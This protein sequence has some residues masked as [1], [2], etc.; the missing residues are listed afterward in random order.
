MAVDL[1]I[2]QQ[3]NWGKTNASVITLAEKTVHTQEKYI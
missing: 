2:I 1:L 3:K